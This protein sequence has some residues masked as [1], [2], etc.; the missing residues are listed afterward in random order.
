MM[1]FSVGK[2]H[3]RILSKLLNVNLQLATILDA[4]R[5]IK[6]I[7]NAMDYDDYILNCYKRA[8]ES[9]EESLRTSAADSL[10]GYYSRNEQYETAEQ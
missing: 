6:D 8:L 1:K 10:F 2:I 9:D 3:H 4:Q 5:L 7:P